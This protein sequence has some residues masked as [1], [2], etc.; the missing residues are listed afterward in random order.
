[1]CGIAGLTYVKLFVDYLD[2][3]E[4]LGDDE[5]GRLFTALM[6]YA[7]TGEAPQLGGNE[8]FL[9]PMMRAQ[10]DRDKAE[11]EALS[12]GRSEAGK[13]GAEAKASKAKQ[14]K[15]KLAKP[16]K[17][18][19]DKDEDKDKDKDTSPPIPPAG[20]QD[21][22]DDGDEGFRGFWQAYP[23]RVGKGEAMAEWARLR[24]DGALQAAVL[25]AVAQ[26][27][28][29]AQW[30]QEGGRYIPAPAR[31]LRERRWEDELPPATHSPSYDIGQLEELS[32][33]SLPEN[34]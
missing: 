24:P 34:L 1:M 4:P 9:F 32:V 29:S 30:A 17:P 26:H 18:S 10:V 5:R 31:W 13:K 33:F 20:G 25:A 19:K 6:K 12:K 14:M 7:R 3:V 28:G 16:S 2:A 22:G 27:K 11:L 21:G 23:R 8:R 15:Q